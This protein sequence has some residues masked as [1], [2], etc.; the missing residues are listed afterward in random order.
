MV[1]AVSEADE[2]LAAGRDVATLPAVDRVGLKLT[3]R[4]RTSAL[5]HS[6]FSDE[7]VSLGGRE[8]VDREVD[9]QN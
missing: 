5:D 9:R 4:Q 6:A 3:Y 2:G 8:Q 7:V 1:G